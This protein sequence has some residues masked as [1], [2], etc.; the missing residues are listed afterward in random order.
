[1]VTPGQLS[2][3]LPIGFGFGFRTQYMEMADFSAFPDVL[4]SE[5]L[6]VVYPNFGIIKETLKPQKFGGLTQ[7]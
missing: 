2:A 4:V 1:M 6:L 7:L 3:A 5:I